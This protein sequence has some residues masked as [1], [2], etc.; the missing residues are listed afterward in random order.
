MSPRLPGDME[1]GHAGRDV[2]PAAQ[3]SLKILVINF[4]VSVDIGLQ[5]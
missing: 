3:C 5:A 4:S 2:W 1:I